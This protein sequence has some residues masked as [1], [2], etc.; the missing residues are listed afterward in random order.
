MSCKGSIM[1]AKAK[2]YYFKAPN[3]SCSRSQSASVKTKPPIGICST[4]VKKVA[5]DEASKDNIHLHKKV[6]ESFQNPLVPD[7]C[8]FVAISD[9]DIHFQNL[10]KSGR[11]YQN[12]AKHFSDVEVPKFIRSWN[13]SKKKAF[14]PNVQVKRN[15]KRRRT[16]IDEESTK[17]SRSNRFNSD[18]E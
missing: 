5:E 1:I 12:S 10:G 13:K 14:K 7:I 3:T 9:L 15:I 17:S 8:N 6:S 11:F 18:S 4:G 16:A 2:L